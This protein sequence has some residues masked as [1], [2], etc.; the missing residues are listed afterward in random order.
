MWVPSSITQ[1]LICDHVLPSLLRPELFNRDA[2]VPMTPCWLVAGQP[3]LRKGEA[4]AAALKKEHMQTP[5]FA[6]EYIS[7][8]EVDE[9]DVES[10]KAQQS[11]CDFIRYVIQQQR[12]LI[13]DG[14]MTAATGTALIVDHAQHLAQSPRHMHFFQLLP[15]MLQDTHVICLLCMD[16][17]PSQL[18]R[19]TQRAYRYQRQIFFCAPDKEWRTQ[20]LKERFTKYAAFIGGNDMCKYIT[21]D[22]TEADYSFLAECGAHETEDAFYNFCANILHSVHKPRAVHEGEP[23]AQRVG[24]DTWKRVV[25]LTY[26]KRFLKD[27]GGVLNMTAADALGAEQSFAQCC[28]A[29]VEP[30]TRTPQTITDANLYENG[31]TR[32]QNRDIDEP[33]VEEEEEEEPVNRKRERTE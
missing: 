32:Q 25:D 29:M 10:I 17:P 5:T 13:G 30:E 22:L 20:Y 27:K 21:I 7:I 15:R 1:T 8:P 23:G 31:G 33:Y 9:D 18:S 3:G 19:E 6:I 24:G 4:V 26:C 14:G 2:C 28:T 12:E 16:I 11:K